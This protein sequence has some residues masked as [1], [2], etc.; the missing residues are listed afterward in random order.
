[1]K[2][3]YA[4]ISV[5]VWL[6]A[7]V[8]LINKAG[9]MVMIFFPLYLTHALGFDISLAGVILSLFGLGVILGSYLGGVLTD[10]IGFLPVQIASLFFAGIL[11]L[12]LEHC[13]SLAW[14][15][16]T[17]F[18]IGLISSWLRPA[19]AATIARFTPRNDR[20]LAYAMN[21][22]ALNLGSTVG[23]ALGGILANINYVWLFRVDGWVNI[24]AAFVMW[25]FFR[26]RRDVAIEEEQPLLAHV[27]WW[28]NRIFTQ[29]LFFTFLTGLIFLFLINIYPLY[30]RDQ[31]S[32]SNFQIG[33]VLGVNG[34]VIILLQ[35][36][37]TAFL[38]QFNILRVIGVGGFLVGLG[39]LIL[40]F[41]TGMWCA[42]I[43]MI[44]ITLGEMAS[45]PFM[46]NF[47]VKIA[48]RN[49]QGKYLGLMT[50]AFQFPMFLGPLVGTYIYSHY[51]VNTLWY[52]AAAIGLVIFIGFEGLNT[53]YRNLP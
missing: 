31:Y 52:F 17:L 53:R 19:T 2:N 42:I 41:Y 32:F 37:L 49:A 34:L 29:F 27:A 9:S 26:N 7:A 35:M 16:L 1:L 3:P 45:L 11:Y 44:I 23:P 36:H 4:N 51:G 28:K 39:Y 46:N 38:K 14:I 15:M 43:S 33:I 20:P 30:L 10:K 24:F 22:Q 48:P 5:A 12:L 8:T 25:L 18:S 13:H 40:P 6:L 47:I 50:S 21:Y